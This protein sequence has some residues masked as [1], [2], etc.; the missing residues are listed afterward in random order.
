MIPIY[1][2]ASRSKVISHVSLPHIVQLIT[3]ERFAPEVG[4]RAGQRSS[5]LFTCWG[6]G[7][8]CFAN[9]YILLS[10][11]QAP[12]TQHPSLFA[13]TF[14]TGEPY[15]IH[16]PP[17]DLVPDRECYFD[18]RFQKVESVDPCTCQLSRE[19]TLTVSLYKPKR[20]LTP[21]QFSVFYRGEECLGSARIL[22]IGPS[23][24]AL[25]Q[26]NNEIPEEEI[27]IKQSSKIS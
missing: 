10:E 7:H 11:F 25:K 19:N 21:G 4:Q 18:F 15:W 6:R 16:R 22:K 27:D 8:Y 14:Y 1:I 2:Q 20:A 23:E 3:Q 26:I 17:P 13:R 24:Y 12:G 9:I 5:L